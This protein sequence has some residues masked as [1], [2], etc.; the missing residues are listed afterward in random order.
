MIEP[1]DRYVTTLNSARVLTFAGKREPTECNR[2]R[3]MMQTSE[4][5]TSLHTLH[6]QHA[7]LPD[8]TACNTAAI[9]KG[10]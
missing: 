4:Q 1:T 2:H 6:N 7:Q 10:A 5:W 3:T 8:A 9:C